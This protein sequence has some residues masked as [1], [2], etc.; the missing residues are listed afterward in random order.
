MPSIDPV[1][2]AFDD[3][4]NG[5]K[6]GRMAHA[7]IVVGPPRS[8]G[9]EFAIKVLSELF[10]DGDG[11]TRDLAS[12]PDIIWVEP[13]KKSRVISVEQVRDLC[14]R[15]ARTSY[16]GGWKGCVIIGADRLG[17]QAANALLKTLEEPS[18]QT[19]FLLLTEQ[20]EAL[21][22]TV[23]SRCQ[24]I[25]L[26]NIHDSLHEELRR[27]LVLILSGNAGGETLSGIVPARRLMAILDELKKQFEE[28]ARSTSADGDD[29]DTIVARGTARYREARSAILRFM[30]LWYRDIMLSVFGVDETHL[31]NGEC[32]EQIRK[33]AV[34]VGFGAAIRKVEA[35]GTLKNQLDRNLDETSV[36][37]MAFHCIAAEK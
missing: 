7:Y 15:L 29:E 30:M 33:N 28:E 3:F 31:H 24:K 10:P 34:G 11:R 37:S 18:G 26:V 23:A 2:A 32:V 16:E 6:S 27:E 22:P 25:V 13:E 4:K 14:M 35:V 19:V 17:D 21:L 5:L 8:E 1:Q 9:R 12:H 20:P 36:F